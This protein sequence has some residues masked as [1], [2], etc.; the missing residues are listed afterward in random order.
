MKENLMGSNAK[1]ATGCGVPIPKGHFYNTIPV[2]EAQWELGKRERKDCKRQRNSKRTVRL[3]PRSRVWDSTEGLPQQ[4]PRN[5]RISMHAA[6][7]VVTHTQSHSQTMNCGQL[8]GWEG[9]GV[10]DQ[11]ISILIGY[12]IQSTQPWNHVWEITMN[13]HNNLSLKLY[14]YTYN[15]PDERKRLGVWQGVAGE[16]K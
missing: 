2:P 13:R 4:E 8:M 10:S 14:A 16:R 12:Q 3:C 5:A 7:K 1:N 6:Q 9:E 15:N 11:V